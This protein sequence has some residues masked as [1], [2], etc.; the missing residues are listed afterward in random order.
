MMTPTLLNLAA[1]TG[2]H[3]HG[4]VY[5]AVDLLEPILSLDYTKGNKNCT[6]WI[7]THFGYT[8]SSSKAPIGSTNDVAYTKH[9]AFLQMWLFKCLTC[10][11]CGQTTKEVQP[12]D[13]ALADC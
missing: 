13:E 5:S 8:M 9:V 3:P 10:L 2:L 6:N 11:K 4:M 7:K 12:L 1:I